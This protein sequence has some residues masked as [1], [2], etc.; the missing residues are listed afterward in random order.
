MK[1]DYYIFLKVTRVMKD[2]LVV[3]LDHLLLYLWE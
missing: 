1:N 2:H 3:C